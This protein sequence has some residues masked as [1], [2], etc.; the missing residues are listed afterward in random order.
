MGSAEKEYFLSLMR[1]TQAVSWKLLVSR[2]GVRHQ[3]C[4]PPR[5]LAMEDS[6]LKKSQVTAIEVTFILKDQ[7]L[8]HRLLQAIPL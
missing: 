6:G 5:S 8:P 1:P 2:Q 3:E 4:S 7:P